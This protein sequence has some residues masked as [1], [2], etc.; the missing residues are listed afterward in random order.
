MKIL[1]IEE[2]TDEISEI[3]RAED[4]FLFVFSNVKSHALILPL[5]ECAR[6]EIYFESE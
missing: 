2:L 1:C 4:T 3:S 5:V 6:E